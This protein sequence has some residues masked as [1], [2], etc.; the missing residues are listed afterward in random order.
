[1]FVWLPLY[2]MFRKGKFR[3]S[4]HIGNFLAVGSEKRDWL[5]MV[6]R[7]LFGVMEMF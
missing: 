4:K 2:E 7:E 6:M 5:Q 1:M 3:D